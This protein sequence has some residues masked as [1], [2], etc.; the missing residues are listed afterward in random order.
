MLPEVHIK[1]QTIHHDTILKSYKGMYWDVIKAILL[2]CLVDKQVHA[3]KMQYVQTKPQDN[4]T[5]ICLKDNT[6]LL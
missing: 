5:F 1:V 6:G 4:M 2:T 3:N